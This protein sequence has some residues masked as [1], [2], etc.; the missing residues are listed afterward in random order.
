MEL[1]QPQPSVEMLGVYML[2]M[3]SHHTIK[4]MELEINVHLTPLP[5]GTVTLACFAAQ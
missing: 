3:S 1:S 4:S 5:I 2:K